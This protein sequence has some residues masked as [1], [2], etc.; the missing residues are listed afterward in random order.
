MWGN[1]RLQHCLLV[2]VSPLQFW[3]GYRIRIYWHNCFS[4]INVMFLLPNLVFFVFYLG[5]YHAFIRESTVERW[6]KMGGG[7]RYDSASS[8]KWLLTLGVLLAH[9]QRSKPPESRSQRSLSQPS[10]L[11]QALAH[12]A[13]SCQRRN[14]ALKRSSST[15]L[16]ILTTENVAG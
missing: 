12:I 3:N 15:E 7:E 16:D 2:C 9:W 4:S 1:W 8:I 14:T 13:N 5:G 10:W 6:Q 11:N